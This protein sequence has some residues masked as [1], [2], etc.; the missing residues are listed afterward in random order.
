MVEGLTSNVQKIHLTVVIVEEEEK[1]VGE[2]E[3]VVEL[4]QQLRK[5]TKE[6]EQLRQ[7]KGGK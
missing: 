6:K 1:G 5:V 7:T 3:S 2:G 4:R